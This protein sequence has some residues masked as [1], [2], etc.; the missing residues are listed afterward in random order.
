[1]KQTA[2]LISNDIITSLPYFDL[3]VETSTDKTR[4]IKKTD[5]N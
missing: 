3:I 5:G 2:K 4:L 1:M